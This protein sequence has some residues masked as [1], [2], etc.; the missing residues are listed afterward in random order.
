MPDQCVVE[1]LGLELLDPLFALVTAVVVAARQEKDKSCDDEQTEGQAQDGEP[2]VVND[3]VGAKARLADAVTARF[4]TL[5][6]V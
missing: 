1:D 4:G 6:Q 3:V 2:E 5:W